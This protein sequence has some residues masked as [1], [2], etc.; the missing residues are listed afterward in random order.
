MRPTNGR[1]DGTEP[2]MM[3]RLISMQDQRAMFTPVTVDDEGGTHIRSLLVLE[4]EDL[5]AKGF[6]RERTK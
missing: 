3:A 2:V 5:Q 6:G 1:R 4:N